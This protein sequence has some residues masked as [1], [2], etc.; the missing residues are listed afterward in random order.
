MFKYKKLLQQAMIIVMFGINSAVYTAHYLIDPY[1]MTQIGKGITVDTAFEEWGNFL[2]WSDT[3]AS[4]KIGGFINPIYT[5]D[6]LI[7]VEGLYNTHIHKADNTGGYST[8]HRSVALLFKGNFP[9][10]ENSDYFCAAGIGAG[11]LEAKKYMIYLFEIGYN[12]HLYNGVYFS[13]T[14]RN[15]VHNTVHPD[16]LNS[17]SDFH[18]HAGLKTY[19]F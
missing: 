18:V 4:V 9:I 6:W 11:G 19:W 13:L 3:S 5:D 2:R 1:S 17:P 15:T 7:S 12:Q 8:S 10:D 14:V 16:S